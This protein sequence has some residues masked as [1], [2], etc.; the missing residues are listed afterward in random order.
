LLHHLKRI[1]KYSIKERVYLSLLYAENKNAYTEMGYGM[2]NNYF[3]IGGFLG[4]KGFQFL[5]VGIRATIAI[6]QHW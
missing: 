4:M 1:A 5:G 6:D 2:G 3:N